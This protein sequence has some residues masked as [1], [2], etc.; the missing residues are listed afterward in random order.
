M[1][2][3]RNTDVHV[4]TWPSLRRPDGRT[5]ELGPGEKVDLDVDVTDVWLKRAGL[6]PRRSARKADISAATDVAEIKE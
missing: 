2:S 3:Y 4:R 5:L 1:A 6:E